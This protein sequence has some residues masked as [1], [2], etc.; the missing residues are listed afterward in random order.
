MQQIVID[1]YRE[2][3]QGGVGLFIVIVFMGSM[4]YSTYRAEQRADM[5]SRN[6]TEERIETNK[7]LSDISSTTRAIQHRL[8]VLEMKVENNSKSTK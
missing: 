6:M 5:Y 4:L 1:L 8:G 2:I 3:R 7:I